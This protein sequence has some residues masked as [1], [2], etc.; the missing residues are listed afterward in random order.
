MR[1]SDVGGV[2]QCLQ[3]IRELWAAYE[4][5]KALERLMLHCRGSNPPGGAEFCGS[6]ARLTIGVGQWRLARSHR[7]ALTWQRA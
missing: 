3:M 2:E 1:L 6:A 4:A 5:T 7:L